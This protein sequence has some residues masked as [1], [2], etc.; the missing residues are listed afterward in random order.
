MIFCANFLACTSLGFPN[1]L[2][3]NRKRRKERIYDDKE[4]L[5]FRLP[6][7][8]LNKFNIFQH[9]HNLSFMCSTMT[10]IKSIYFLYRIEQKY[11]PQNREWGEFNQS[12]AGAHQPHCQQSI[13][14]TSTFTS[15]FQLNRNPTHHDHMLASI[16]H[17]L[18]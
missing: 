11:D 17:S 18:Y 7:M 3:S 8:L 5:T 2:S 10:Y 15:H 14:I 9:Q 12:L 1:S 4:G 13:F 6:N 16:S